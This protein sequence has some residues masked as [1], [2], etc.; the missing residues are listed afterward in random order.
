M[1][2]IYVEWYLV[3]NICIIDEIIYISDLGFIVLGVVISLLVCSY[4]RFDRGGLVCIGYY[5]MFLSFN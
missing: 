4:G 5:S 2:L 1:C 3:F